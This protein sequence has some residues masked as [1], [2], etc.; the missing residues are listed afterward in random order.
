MSKYYRIEL[1]RKQYSLLNYVI[2]EE[3]EYA[4]HPPT[5]LACNRHVLNGIGKA[6]NNF[7]VSSR[8]KITTKK[9]E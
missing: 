7:E 4:N 9:G 8:R 5:R 2:R 6:F 1:T 3:L